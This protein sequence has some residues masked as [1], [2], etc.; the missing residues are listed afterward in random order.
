MIRKFTCENFKNVQATDL[1]FSRINLLIGPNNKGK[2]NFLR[3][4]CLCSSTLN[5]MDRAS[6]FIISAVKL[7]GGVK[8]LRHGANNREIYLSWTIDD[9]HGALE[10]GTLRYQLA[11]EIGNTVKE[12]HVTAESLC[13]KQSDGTDI[14]VH[15]ENYPTRWGANAPLQDENAFFLYYFFLQCAFFSS[16]AFDYAKIRQFQT[17]DT[18]D[19]VLSPDGGNFLNVYQTAASEDKEFQARFLSVMKDLSSDLIDIQLE[20][21]LGKIG[22]KLT[23]QN[24]A[25]WLSEVSDGTVEAMLVS[26]L[27]T[28]PP[29]LA[30]KVLCLDEPE[31]LLHPA[32][33][34][35]IANW[36][37]ISGNVPQCFIST[38]SPDFLDAF[39]DGFRR[40]SVQILVFDSDSTQ[41]VEKLDRE[42]LEPELAKG[43]LLGDLY[44]VGD[45]LIGGWPE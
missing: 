25:F 28:L 40:G 41:T 44:R 10:G 21:G 6:D 45:P 15:H 1:N 23:F 31:I 36:I 20:E 12:T 42:K 35:V 30:P 3:A 33:Q 43:W 38:H 17:P 19:Q 22:M 11:F 32:W 39:T 13:L 34:K 29:D 4:L 18:G 16:S 5:S 7:N 8:I 9:E 26:L 2:S 37:Q 14:R 27:L 24:G